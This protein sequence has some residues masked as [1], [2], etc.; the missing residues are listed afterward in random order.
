[1]RPHEFFISRLNIF[2]KQNEM[3]IRPFWDKVRPPPSGTSRDFNRAGNE[4]PIQSLL[5]RGTAQGGFSVSFA[6]QSGVNRFKSIPLGMQSHL[7]WTVSNAFVGKFPFL[8]VHDSRI[9]KSR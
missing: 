8:G 1:M 6:R 9:G 7:G 5:R 2:S 4:R 3:G